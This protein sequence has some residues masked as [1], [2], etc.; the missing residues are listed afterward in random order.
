MHNGCPARKGDKSTSRRSIQQLKADRKVKADKKVKAIQSVSS[1]FKSEKPFFLV[2]M[3]PSYVGLT[4]TCR[5]ALPSLF[6]R[7]HL[8]KEPCDVILCNSNGKTWKTLYATA[9]LRTGWET[10][11]QD[12]NIRVGDVCAF[13]LI[14]CMEISFKV[15]IYQGQNA[16]CHES[17]PLTEVFLPRGLVKRNAGTSSSRPGYLE[18]LDALENAKAFQ[19][20]R[21]F[22]SEN[23]FFVVALQPSY[24][25]TNKMSIPQSF[26]R[27]Y[28]TK[29]LKKVILFLSNGKS[30]PVKYY[31]H[32]FES[33]RAKLSDK[34]RKNQVELQES[35]EIKTES[36][37]VDDKGDMSS[38]QNQRPTEEFTVPKINE[39]NSNASGEILEEASQ[40]YQSL[41][42]IWQ[43]K[44]LMGRTEAFD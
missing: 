5:L 28:L 19:I 2:V 6:V 13:E 37:S 9:R 34:S 22:R 10:F 33:S 1:A 39:N 11:V 44:I 24:V 31:Q 4:R 38:L 36:D 7:K 43:S 27:K 30:W 25:N 18:P 23:P 20:A 29:M 26:A 17:L 3:Q 41:K 8:M 15:V 14:N 12:N 42:R 16:N 35:L 21:A 32:S 40:R